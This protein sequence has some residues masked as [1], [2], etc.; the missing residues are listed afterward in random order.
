MLLLQKNRCRKR[1]PL[2]V[3]KTDSQAV[4]EIEA[5]S[6]QAKIYHIASE[7][8]A[9]TVLAQ[10][11]EPGLSASSS[12]LILY[13]AADE[14]KPILMPN[15]KQRPIDEVLAFLSLE[16]INP[17]ILHTPV[18]PDHRCTN[19]TV[20]DQRPL[21]GSFFKPIPGKPLQVQL[22]VSDKHSF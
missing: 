6:F 17:T 3:G 10:T 2:S 1:C 5:L 15:F 16:G 19:C 21:A 18:A 4:A 14:Q 22:Q 12:S 9:G 8:V 13:I 11:P 20:V 7:Q